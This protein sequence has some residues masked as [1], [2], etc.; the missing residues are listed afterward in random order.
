MALVL[1][2][3]FGDRQNAAEM[4]PDATVGHLRLC[5]EQMF[6]LKTAFTL[7]CGDADFE[8][9]SA[10]LADCGVCAEA[11]VT[12]NLVDTL[13]TIY[14][15]L[16]EEEKVTYDTLLCGWEPATMSMMPPYF[17]RC[18]PFFRLRQVPGNTGMVR[19]SDLTECINCCTFFAES[20]KEL[21][22]TIY[23]TL[24]SI[25]DS[26][27]FILVFTNEIRS[28]MCQYQN[29]KALTLDEQKEVIAYGIRNGFVELN[30]D[31]DDD[32]PP[33][34][35]APTMRRHLDPVE[36]LCHIV[37]H[38][39]GMRWLKYERHDERV[40][41]RLRAVRADRI[42]A[43]K[44]DH[45][46]DLLCK[47]LEP[48]LVDMNIV[49]EHG[50]SATG[51][52]ARKLR[53]MGRREDTEVARNLSDSRGWGMCEQFLTPTQIFLD[54]TRSL[55]QLEKLVQEARTRLD[56]AVEDFSQHDPDIRMKMETKRI[57]EDEAKARMRLRS[58]QVTAYYDIPGM[59]ELRCYGDPRPRPRPCG[60]GGGAARPRSRGRGGGGS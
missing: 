25:E 27:E 32:M 4:A 21:C 50:S 52:L 44:R 1:Y 42:A 20:H 11:S 28:F 17:V 45:E 46:A 13:Y 2:L 23:S 15:S 12:V 10:L 60:R 8:D 40:L 16:T 6:D 36:M 58:E 34:A 24:E 37:R 31:S 47:R 35:C 49:D 22:G 55:E 56:G 39:P 38:E 18:V 43:L 29:F 53:Q 51:R 26:P 7:A 14:L 41:D 19:Y 57:C 9:D 33:G 30:G 48:V 59:E 5:A 54:T 3:R